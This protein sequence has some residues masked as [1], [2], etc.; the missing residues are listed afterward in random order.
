MTEAANN[1]NVIQRPTHDGGE[2]YALVGHH[3]IMFPLLAAS[4]I[5][6]LETKK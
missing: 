2:G 3:E 4:V 5:E 6:A 1:G